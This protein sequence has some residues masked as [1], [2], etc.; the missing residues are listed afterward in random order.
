MK[1]ARVLALCLLVAAAWAAPVQDGF[2]DAELDVLV[3]DTQNKEIT[4]VEIDVDS[5]GEIDIYYDDEQVVAESTVMPDTEDSAWLES[6][7]RAED[8]QMPDSTDGFAETEDY[9]DMEVENSPREHHRGSGHSGRSDESSDESSSGSS[10]SAREKFHKAE[11][12][13]QSFFHKACH[14]FHGLP[15]ALRVLVVAGLTLV[16]GLVAYALYRCCRGCCCP[17]SSSPSSAARTRTVLFDKAN[18]KYQSLPTSDEDAALKKSFDLYYVP[19]SPT[20]AAN[21]FELV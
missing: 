16:F 1:M 18:V 13:V 15:F 6:T 9:Y 8:T 11:Q 7:V 5:N 2:Y 19:A 20:K 4:N 21:S 12:A 3:V 14:W 17:S 10:A